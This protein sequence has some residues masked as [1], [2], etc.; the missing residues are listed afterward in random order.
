MMRWLVHGFCANFSPKG[1][2]SM[3]SC[4]ISIPVSCDHWSVCVVWWF[5]S[6][7][8][9]FR[10]YTL[11]C[12]VCSEWAVFL[13][14]LCLLLVFLLQS[15]MRL[16]AF[17]DSC[18]IISL[19]FSYWVMWWIFIIHRISKKWEKWDYLFLAGSAVTFGMCSKENMPF[20]LVSGVRFVHFMSCVG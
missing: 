20:I 8:L 13:E 4:I 16:F 7:R 1:F 19:R 9:H 18:M 2:T 15:P 14:K 6:D 11:D 17:H 5:E 10:V 12:V 3:I